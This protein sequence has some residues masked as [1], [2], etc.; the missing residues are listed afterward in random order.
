VSRSLLA[1]ALAA[2]LATAPAGRAAATDPEGGEASRPRLV[3]DVGWDA[4]PTY[5]IGCDLPVSQRHDPLDLTRD[6]RLRGRVGGSLFLDGGHLGG[7]ALDD[8]WR[9]LVRKLRLLTRGDLLR[10]VDTQYKFEFAVDDGRFFLNDFYLRWRDPAARIWGLRT[11]VQTLRIGNLQPPVSLES[12]ASSSDRS[13][14]EL[15]SPASA[16]APA[17]Q[18]GVEAA[19]T[20]EHPDLTWAAA[21]STLGQRQDEQDASRTLARLT[22]RLVWRPWDVEGPGAE[23]LLHL[24][25]SVSLA[26]AG[27][28]SVRYRARPESYLADYLLD[29]GDVDGNSR[30][31]ALEAAWRRGP[32]T[33]EG[34]LFESFVGARDEGSLHFSGLYGQATWVATGE[35][36]PYDRSSAVFGRLVPREPFAPWRGGW[37]ALELA[38]RVSWLDLED[39]PVRGG[40]MLTANLGFTWTWNA[41]VRVQGGYVFAWVRGRPDEGL[42]HIVQGRLELRF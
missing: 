15:G 16:F 13:L 36:R 38:G 31:I 5:E 19:G 41:W 18:P 1:G 8:E 40:R 7:S 14:M 9:F 26:Q 33:L 10:W 30:L 17:Y 23:S 37:G 4:A 6:V 29:T 22:G 12:I 28:G 35:V 25:A 32:W 20:A 39:G 21:F 2:A 3:F 24:G 34:E 42:A 11:L 27:P